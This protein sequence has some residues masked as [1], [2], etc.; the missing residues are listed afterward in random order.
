MKGMMIGWLLAILFLSAADAEDKD[1]IA[2][3]SRVVSASLFKN[4]LAVIQREVSLPGAGEFLL[5]ETPE[6]IHGTFWIDG[7]DEVEARTSYRKVERRRTR[8]AAGTFAQLA[9]QSVRIHLRASGEPVLA[10]R[11]A[12]DSP[13]SPPKSR[14][15]LSLFPEPSKGPFPVPIPFLQL[16]TSTGKVFVNPAD[17]LYVEADAIGDHETVEQPVLRL[18]SHGEG[19]RTLRLTYISTGLSWAPSYRVDISDRQNLSLRQSAVIRNE[20]A[21][22][23]DTE[24]TLISG[25]PNI[26]FASVGSPMAPWSSW[27]LFFDQLDRRHNM[28]RQGVRSQIAS[29]VAVQ[30]PATDNGGPADDRWG[31]GIDIHEQ[32]MGRRSLDV[33]ESASLVTADARTNYER[34]VYWLIPDQRSVPYRGSRGQGFFDR[35]GEDE[36]DDQGPPVA[37]DTL[38]FKN[39]FDFPMTTAPA[40][41]VTGSQFNG[42]AMMRWSNPGEKTKLRV[43]KALSIRTRHREFEET[44]PQAAGVPN[45]TRIGDSLYQPM[46]VR[47]E[48]KIVN[49]RGETITLHIRARVTGDLKHADGEPSKETLEEGI[50]SVNQRTELNWRMALKPR[51]EKEINYKYEVLVKR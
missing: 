4:G 32:K 35:D 23:R 18:V 45:L 38:E 44:R 10:G 13:N 40:M 27:R 29:N 20:M 15:S 48:L 41:V 14:D 28:Q 33:G 26:P 24:I 12:I 46:T 22:L 34:I 17:I 47:G 30:M 11:L 19:A 49:Q 3:P 6:F 51:E 25:F 36:W 39:P 37:W 43:N 8:P 1:A 21:E 7:G 9:G 5:E 42:Q 50:F 16:D 2:L 31:D